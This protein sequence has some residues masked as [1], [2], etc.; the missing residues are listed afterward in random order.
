MATGVGWPFLAPPCDEEKVCYTCKVRLPWHLG[1]SG[2]GN[3]PGGVFTHPFRDLCEAVSG[4]ARE[5]EH[6]HD[7]VKKLSVCLQ[8]SA[9]EQSDGGLG[10]R[11]SVTE[12]HL[13]ALS[14]SIE[15]L[16]NKLERREETTGEDASTATCLRDEPP[17]EPAPATAGR[18]PRRKRNAKRKKKSTAPENDADG[19]TQDQGED[20]GDQ[21]KERGRSSQNHNIAQGQP[22]PRTQYRPLTED[23]DEQMWELVCAR[24][25]QPREQKTVLYIGNVDKNS[26]EARLE[27]FI[28]LR[29]G[30]DLCLQQEVVIY[31]STFF[32]DSKG[33]TRSYCG[34][35][36]TVNADAENILLNKS[37]W[38][39]PLYCRRW[40]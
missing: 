24:K 29:A 1:K 7:E 5:Y 10:Y 25:P 32:K 22:P 31:N 37:F 33:A 15:G 4:L 12:E 11:V 9:S 21:E 38:P 26:D 14:A 35:R 39:A 2:P 27:N 28:L 6:L 13:V 18:S 19:P 23:K 8:S 40:D 16:Q 3:C 36:I 34:A 17:G 30:E 20:R